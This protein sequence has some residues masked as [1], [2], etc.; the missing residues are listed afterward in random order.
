MA[1]G[2]LKFRGIGL[3][4]AGVLF[5]G[6][7]V[8]HFGNPVDEAVEVSYLA[9]TVILMRYFEVQGTV[10]QAISVVK[11]RSGDHERTIREC[12]VQKGGLHVGE[13]LR[14]F[15]G[16]LTGVPHYTGAAAPLLEESHTTGHPDRVAE[17]SSEAPIYADDGVGEHAR[18]RREKKS[19][20]GT[21]AG[22]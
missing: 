3:G 5:A 14:D 16:V 7:V 17:Q 11:K 19:G 21:R 2:S 8:G 6:I 12:R 20:G 4:T 22:R 13:P 15:Q 1:L 10:R 18:K 9:D